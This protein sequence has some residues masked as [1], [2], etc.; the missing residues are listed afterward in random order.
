MYLI[1][2]VLLQYVGR[3]RGGKKYLQTTLDNS[4]LLLHLLGKSV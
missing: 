1:L 4:E 2:D 3:E